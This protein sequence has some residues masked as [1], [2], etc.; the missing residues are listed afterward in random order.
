MLGTNSIAE[1]AGYDADVNAGIANEF[2]SVA[3][4]FGHSM[5]SPFMSRLNEDGT[6]IDEGNLDLRDAFFA[7]Q[8]IIDAH[9]S[10]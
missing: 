2:S 8:L 9:A 3:Y 4:R 6:P 10:Q 1:Y 7:P 5:V